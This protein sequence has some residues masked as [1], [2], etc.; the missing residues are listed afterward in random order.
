MLSKGLAYEEIAQKHLTKA[1]L[2]TLDKNFCCRSGEI[3]LIMLDRSTL[4]FIEV[5]FRKNSLY[6]SA[7]ESVNSLKQRKIIKTAEYYLTKKDLWHLATRFDVIAI[8]P[9][10]ERPGDNSITW[11]KSAFIC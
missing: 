1:G 7:A 3:D 9:S 11:H 10:T 2:K 6:G 4:V 5:R 8:T